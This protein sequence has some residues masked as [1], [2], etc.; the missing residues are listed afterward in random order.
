M[1]FGTRVLRRD[2]PHTGLARQG[3]PFFFPFRGSWWVPILPLGFCPGGAG[4]DTLLL[5]AGTFQLLGK[6]SVGLGRTRCRVQSSRGG[7]RC[8]IPLFQ[9]SRRIVF[10]ALKVHLLVFFLKKSRIV[11]ISE[12]SPILF[13]QIFL[14]Q[15]GKRTTHGP[16]LSPT[17]AGVHVHL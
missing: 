13:R 10:V 2:P 15:S 8:L 12:F 17:T 9:A 1:R 4:L 7:G 3:V 6:R 11:S 16:P 14:S 5:T